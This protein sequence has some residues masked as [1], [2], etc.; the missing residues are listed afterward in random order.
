[1]N[2]TFVIVTWNNENQIGNLLNSIQHYEPQSSIVIVDNDS[3][4][5]T[6]HNIKSYNDPKVK[7]IKSN[8]NLGF[9]KANNLA[10]RYVHTKYITFINPDTCLHQPLISHLSKELTK[11]IGVI[12]VKILNEDGSLQPSKYCFQKPLTI[13]IEQFGV[14]K[15]LPDY[16][17][18]KLSPENTA[19]DSVKEADWLI[20][21]FLFT[22]LSKCQQVGGFSEEYFLY[23]E[24]MDLGYKYHLNRLK[25][26]FDPQKSIIHHG[27]ASEQQ[28]SS[29]KS[30]K[31]LKSFC[32]FARKYHLNDNIKT[33]YRSYQIKALIFKLIDQ[34]RSQRYRNN[35]EFLRRQLK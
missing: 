35:V 13:L 21:A 26:L 33:L 34:Q 25:V 8:Q 2:N 32:T 15:F 10:M 9:A 22:T 27:G 16:L 6:I 7:L 17:K 11:R 29:A 18:N 4:D 24:D 1:M 19:H 20:G 30:L 28:T 14:G 12:G 5:N 31:L 3:S 23:S